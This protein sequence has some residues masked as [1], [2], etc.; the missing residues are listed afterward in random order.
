MLMFLLSAVQ[1]S[2]QLDAQSGLSLDR[3]SQMIIGGN[4]TVSNSSSVTLDVAGNS[5]SPPISVTG[6]VELSGA[7][8][9]RL[10]NSG[11]NI[12]SNNFQ[13]T[14]M[15]Y[16]C[17]NGSFGTVTVDVVN[18]TCDPTA[19]PQYQ[20]SSLVLIVVYRQCMNSAAGDESLPLWVILVIVGVAVL[21]VVAMIVAILI[22]RKKRSRF[23]KEMKKTTAVSLGRR[24]SGN[25]TYA[26]TVPYTDSPGPTVPQVV[27]SET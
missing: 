5:S 9:V 23:R 13:V 24:S 20:E 6:C 15:E 14:V 7:L 21:L 26:P 4:L 12:S 16:D 25:E 8:Q 27:A 17:R 1:E 18:K 2:V 22:V 19:V 10:D 3:I 11:S